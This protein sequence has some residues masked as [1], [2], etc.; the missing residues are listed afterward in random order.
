MERLVVR[1]AHGVQERKYYRFRVDRWYGGI[2]TGD[3]VGCGLSCKFCW[4]SDKVRYRPKEIGSFYSPRQVAERL[5]AL[6]EKSGLSQLRLSGGEPTIGRLHLIELL[7]ELKGSGCSFILETNGIL[8]GH[9]PTYAE[10]LSRYD[11]IHVRVSLKGCSEEEFHRLTGA[12]PEDFRL[13]LRALENLTR[14]GV[15]CHPAAMISFS[16]RES[17]KA[18][19][20]RLREISPTLVEEFEVEELILYPH[21]VKRLQAYG[22]RYLTGHDPRRVPPDQI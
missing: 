18:L 13:Q 10:Q 12:R 19:M 3:C 6:A 15:E 9:D 7:D 1:P 5:L 22:L 4:V 8:L 16:S 2:V 14:C 21:V 20:E 11:F 17:L